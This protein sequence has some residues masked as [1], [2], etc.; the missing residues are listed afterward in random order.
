MT[1]IIIQDIYNYSKQYWNKIKSKEV[2]EMIII[3]MD[4]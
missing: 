2:I 4:N 3:D 1:K